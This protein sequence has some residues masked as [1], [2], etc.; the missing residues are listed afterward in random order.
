MIRF[1]KPQDRIPAANRPFHLMYGQHEL[2]T[3]R[4]GDRR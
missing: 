4:S 1:R 3:G 2:L